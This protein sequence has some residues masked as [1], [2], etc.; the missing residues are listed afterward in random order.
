MNLHVALQK[1]M[2][3]TAVLALCKLTELLKV[4][5][6]NGLYIVG[7]VIILISLNC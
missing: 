6:L 2:T 1:P 5:T 4:C 7:I 3:K